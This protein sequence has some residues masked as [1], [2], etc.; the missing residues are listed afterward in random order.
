[1]MT[2]SVTFQSL[3]TVD[4]V[5]D[6]RLGGER[7]GLVD[8]G[9]DVL[10]LA[11]HRAVHEGSHDRHVGVVATHVPGVTA[12]GCDWRAAGHVLLVVSARRHF[13]ARSHVHEIAAF[14]VTPWAGL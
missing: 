8:G 9:V 3:A 7:A 11:R 5:G 1:M 6:R 14:V 12:A 2:A 4:V 10:P 13:T